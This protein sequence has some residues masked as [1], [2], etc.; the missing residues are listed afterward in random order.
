MEQHKVFTTNFIKY[1]TY[2]TSIPLLNKP[3]YLDLL[4]IEHEFKIVDVK[5]ISGLFGNPST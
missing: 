1:N 5:D 2:I 3:S 4:L